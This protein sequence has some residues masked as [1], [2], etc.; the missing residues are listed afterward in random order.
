MH[1]ALQHGDTITVLWTYNCIISG[2]TRCPRD[3]GIRVLMQLHACCCTEHGKEEERVARK[4]HF[5][6]DKTDLHL[7]SITCF[8]N[9]LT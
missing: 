7:A 8:N 2:D 9:R 5:E 6:C 1:P 4:R 3:G